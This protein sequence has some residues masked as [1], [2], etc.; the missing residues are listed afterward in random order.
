MSSESYEATRELL[1]KSFRVYDTA[2]F[3]ILSNVG[4]RR[5]RAQADL[6]EQTH[7]EFRR[8]TERLRLRPLP[9]RHKLVCVLLRS[10]SE[11]LEFASRHESWAMGYYSPRNHRTVFYDGAAEPDA[12]PF[13][14]QRSVATTIH[15]A[16]HQLHYHT[17]VQ[18]RYVQYPL[19]SCEGLATAFETDRSADPFGPDH[20]FRPRQERF[21]R[22][23]S[24]DRLL[25][26]RAF[27]QLDRMPDSRRE[28][29]HIVYNQ[30]YA[31]VSWLARYRRHRLREYLMVMLREPPGRPSPQRHLE[32]F[33]QAFGDVDVLE[34]AW[35]LREK[36]QLG[37]SAS[38]RI[39]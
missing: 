26:L 24:E 20:E 25:S 36:T 15:E 4:R 28:T 33:E 16:I 22:L 32:L 18:T 38:R 27:I 3:V 5:A 37:A 8:H 17:R 30:S 14:Q 39:E 35:L 9:R 31:L 34:Q 10:R 7:A 13:A 29:V 1:P 21:R 11:F 2:R 19:W 12:D 23:L 6:L